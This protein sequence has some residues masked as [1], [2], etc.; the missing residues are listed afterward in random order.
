MAA[1]ALVLGLPVA[2]SACDAV[3]VRTASNTSQPA[4]VCSAAKPGTE[5]DLVVADGD[6]PVVSH[7]HK[8]NDGSLL[9]PGAGE[10]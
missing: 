2:S 8:L 4:E 6:Q 1:A 3:S 7:C 10:Q 9:C 5:C